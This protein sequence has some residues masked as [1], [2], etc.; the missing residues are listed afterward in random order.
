MKMIPGVA[1]VLV[2]LVA[3]V[4]LAAVPA[5]Q[6]GAAAPAAAAPQAAVPDVA[7]GLPAEPTA[8]PVAMVE[9]TFTD[10]KTVTGR[11]LK[12]D[13]QA[14]QVSA[15]GGGG[16]SIGY[17][18][19]TIRSIRRFTMSASQFAEQAADLLAGQLWKVVDAPGTFVKAREQYR[20]AMALAPAAEDRDRLQAKLDSLEH[21]REA[22]QAETL[23]RSE[24]QKAKDEAELVRLQKDLTQQQLAALQAYEL[25]LR[26]VEQ[27]VRQTMLA[28]IELQDT[29][30]RMG[31]NLNDLNNLQRNNP[32]FVP[33]P[34]YVDVR[35]PHDDQKHDDQK[36]DDQKNDDC[37]QDKDTPKP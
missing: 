24:V 11:L 25:R 9:L 3:S 7:I 12:E 16:G 26:Q 34:V 5:D 8:A 20:A 21:E 33:Y 13:D 29:S 2:A 28:I 36:P 19:A 1:A 30:T 18:R 37:H 35:R 14:V 4:V 27:N 15:L 10:G 6:Q 23:R 31:Q 32:V 17:Q 22:W